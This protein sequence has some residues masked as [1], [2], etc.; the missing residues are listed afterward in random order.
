MCLSSASCVFIPAVDSITVTLSVRFGGVSVTQRDFT[1]YD[2]TAVKQL[3]GS[4]P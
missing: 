4:K 3:S 1:F 2:C